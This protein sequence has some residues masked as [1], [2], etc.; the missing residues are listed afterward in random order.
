MGAS[1]AVE[2]AKSEAMARSFFAQEKV[3][4]RLSQAR[5]LPYT[6]DAFRCKCRCIH[7]FRFLAQKGSC[8][9]VVIVPSLC[10][11]N[12]VPATAT[13]AELRITVK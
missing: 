7:F 9:G 5:C 10:G 6:T 8:R 2:R 1:R 3:F 13:T 11:G 12:I 4:M